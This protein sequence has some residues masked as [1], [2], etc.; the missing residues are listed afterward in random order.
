MRRLYVDLKFTQ[1]NVS[2][3]D[4][5]VNYLVS[6]TRGNGISLIVN[7]PQTAILVKQLF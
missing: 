3:H 7:R 1:L 5:G 6:R 4:L 2:T